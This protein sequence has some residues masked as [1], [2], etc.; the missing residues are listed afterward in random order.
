MKPTEK[1]ERNP[2]LTISKTL[3]VEIAGILKIGEPVEGEV[4]WQVRD[5]LVKAYDYEILFEDEEVNEVEC[6]SLAIL[7][8]PR[9]LFYL[10]KAGD[11]SL[12]YLK[13]YD[14]KEWQSAREI[15]EE[16]II[17]CS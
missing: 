16:N 5:I 11:R 13:E 17:K 14:E 8:E 15:L 10:I 2:F 4:A 6:Y 3:G 7:L 12:A 9:Y 1:A